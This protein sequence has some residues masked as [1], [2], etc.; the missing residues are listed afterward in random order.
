MAA[1][2]DTEEVIKDYPFKGASSVVEPTEEGK[3]QITMDR[4]TDEG[5]DFIPPETFKKLD[6]KVTIQYNYPIDSFDYFLTFDGH[7]VPMEKA[8]YKMLTDFE[9]A[10]AL[11]KIENGAGSRTSGTRQWSDSQRNNS[12]N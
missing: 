9:D 5:L 12:S 8:M 1:N 2:A 4:L 10:C 11:K 3:L 7:K 6:K